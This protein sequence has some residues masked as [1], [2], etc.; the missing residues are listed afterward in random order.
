[1]KQAMETIN[2]R[3][4]KAWQASVDL[5]AFVARMADS[6]KDNSFKSLATMLVETAVDLSATI[7]QCLA[8]AGEEERKTKL[9][10][11]TNL[12]LRLENLL[13][14]ASRLNLLEEKLLGNSLQVIAEIRR[15]MKEWNERN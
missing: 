4:N 12:S 15:M 11:L 8:V 14:L 3:E 6:F 7:V 10:E 5:A 1:M 9:E 13:F 2:Y